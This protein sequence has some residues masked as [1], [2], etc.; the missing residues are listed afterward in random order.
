[1][2]MPSIQTLLEQ[3]REQSGAL[4]VA[5]TGARG[6]V[7]VPRLGGAPWDAGLAVGERRVL[8]LGPDATARIPR[9][10]MLGAR[11]A[12]IRCEADTRT[13][14]GCSGPR[15]LAFAARGGLSIADEA[16]EALFT[17][18][19]ALEQEREQ[20]ELARRRTALAHLGRAAA[21]AAHDLRN[22]LSTA[23]LELDSLGAGID[24]AMEGLRTSVDSARDLAKDFLELE[25]VPARRPVDLD[26]VLRRELARLPSHAASYTPA[27][28]PLWVAGRRDLVSRI[29]ANLISNSVQASRRG[30]RV[31]VGVRTAGAR[32]ELTIADRGRGMDQVRLDRYLEPGQTRTGSGFGTASVRHCLARIGG[33]LWIESELRKGT[34]CVVEFL[35]A[36]APERPAALVHDPDPV[37][38]W[39]WRE[40]FERQGYQPLEASTAEEAL[41]W[42][43]TGS[44]SVV[45]TP[46]ACPG[47]SRLARG[48]RQA[49]VPTAYTGARV[50]DTRPGPSASLP[51]VADRASPRTFERLLLEVTEPA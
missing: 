24:G 49:G 41:A 5:W 10:Q 9:L 26:A 11:Y 51:R 17:A 30:G 12:A 45:L 43:E 22:E 50:R 33:H 2:E 25:A 7:S 34:R 3:A 23:L 15:R 39:S 21:G 14:L 32:V 18:L 46:R 36:P 13:A 38:R 28:R 37:A 47:T 48:A 35:S 40:V 6:R 19:T 16:V 20:A 44:V 8:R 29:A 1:M 42:L 31:Q 4:A 27:G